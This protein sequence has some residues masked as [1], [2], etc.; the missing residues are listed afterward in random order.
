M[1]EKTGMRKKGNT[2]T[3]RERILTAIGGEKPDRA[4]YHRLG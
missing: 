1:Y 4:L 2:M 3:S